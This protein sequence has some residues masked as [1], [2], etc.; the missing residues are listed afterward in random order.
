MW[1]I[2]RI[3]TTSVS[4]ASVVKEVFC[5]SKNV[6]Y[7]DGWPGKAV[8]SPRL[9]PLTLLHSFRFPRRKFSGPVAVPC[10]AWS[11]KDAMED[12]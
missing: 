3:S 5:Q 1:D 2:F 11:G 7:D 8:A 12:W 9:L 10:D 6:G 4:H